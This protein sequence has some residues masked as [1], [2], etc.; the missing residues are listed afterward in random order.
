MI[1]CE[2]PSEILFKKSRR[3]FL[4]GGIQNCWNWQTVITESLKDSL[5]NDWVVFN[6]RR[7]IWN[8]FIDLKEQIE[9]EV[10]RLKESEHII[11]YFSSDTIQPIVLLEY[12]KYCLSGQYPKKKFYVFIED[13]YERKEDVIHQTNLAF[14]TNVPLFVCESDMSSSD[15]FN[16]VSSML[17][18]L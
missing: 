3:I 13:G 7:K 5:A 15:F 8:A 1:Y 9:W 4:A 18:S 6:P 16:N 10:N 2:A 14:L 17:A 12:G 11:F